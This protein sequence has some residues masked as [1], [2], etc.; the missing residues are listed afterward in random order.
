M[1]KRKWKHVFWKNL[2]PIIKSI[3]LRFVLCIFRICSDSVPYPHHS[4]Y[5][6]RE[7]HEEVLKKVV[8]IPTQSGMKKVYTAAV[9]SL[10]CR[11]PSKCVFGCRLHN[12]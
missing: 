2:D 4:G 5:V 12:S 9:Y 8:F 10:Y 1:I 11:I 6:N 7:R 3:F